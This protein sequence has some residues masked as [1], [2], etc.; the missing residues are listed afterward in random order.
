MTACNAF[1]WG[2]VLNSLRVCKII[3]NYNFDPS[4]RRLA[5][6]HKLSFSI[7]PKKSQSSADGS[8]RLRHLRWLISRPCGGAGPPTGIHHYLVCLPRWDAWR[9][10]RH[11]NTIRPRL[12]KD[13]AAKKSHYIP[14]L[15]QFRRPFVKG[16][17]FRWGNVGEGT[18]VLRLV[19]W[20]NCLRAGSVGEITQS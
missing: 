7:S 15:G 6:H 11:E 18:S 4:H 20:D 17:V 2:R 3:I 13:N 5:V 19:K 16:I 10:V 12:P 8:G 1:L 14:A 9:A